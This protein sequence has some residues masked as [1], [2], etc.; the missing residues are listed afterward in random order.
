MNQLRK[1]TQ[2][3]VDAISGGS[4]QID[5]GIAVIRCVDN[6]EAF[7]LTCSV[8]DAGTTSGTSQWVPRY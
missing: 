1:L 2:N 8:T 6:G 5:F 7:Y 3:E 4:W